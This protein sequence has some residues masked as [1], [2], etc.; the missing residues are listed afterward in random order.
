MGTLVQ[1]RFRNCADTCHRTDDYAARCGDERGDAR[2]FQSQS[3]QSGNGK[4]RAADQLPQ[5]FVPCRRRQVPDDAGV[6]RFSDVCGAS[7]RAVGAGGIPVSR[8]QLRSRRSA[9]DILGPAGR[10]VVARQ[11]PDD[12]RRESGCVAT[13]R[14][15]NSFARRRSDVRTGH[16]AG[17]AGYSRSQHLRPSR[18]GKAAHGKLVALG[19]HCQIHFSCGVCYVASTETCV[20]KRSRE[21]EFAV[22]AQPRSIGM[23]FRSLAAGLALIFLIAVPFATSAESAAPEYSAKDRWSQKRANDWYGA[24]QWLVGSN[25]IP[26]TAINELEMWQADTF[27]LATIDREL[28]WAQNIGMN[29]MRVFLHNLA[30]KQDPAGF[31]DRID[32]FLEIADKH[33]IRIMFVL[34][35]SVWDPNPQ[36][37]K[38]RAPKPHTHNSGWV[39]ATGAAILKN[40]G[41]WSTEIEPY[42]KA[43]VGRFGDDRRIVIWDL[44]NE[45][46]NEN[47][48]Y[49]STEL[50]NKAQ[51]AE[52]LLAKV[53]VWAR[54]A[55]PSQPLTSGVWKKLDFSDDSKLSAM[56]KLQLE[57]SDVITF[58]NYDPPE[59][60][61]AEIQ[62]LR[63]FHRPVICTEYMARPQGS[64]F[65]AVLPVLKGED[66]GAYNWGF[67]SGKSQTIFPWDSWEKQYGD[68]PPL[69]FHD[70]FR[71]DGTPYN[72]KETELILQL[73][74][75]A[76]AS[77]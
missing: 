44:M 16:G 42:V 76:P 61:T 56:E 11:K 52:Q 36:I 14:S 45:P 2:Y 63:H 47:G 34:L 48:Q 58:H 51:V 32:K 39:Q 62:S 3:R 19:P 5:Q 12:Q 4:L 20:T 10:C 27:D 24:Q 41:S 68:E 7:R 38:Q 13:A 72:A 67:V 77:R 18:R 75:T 73:T 50:P 49:K 74:R 8:H 69:W 64:T 70:I 71:G 29:T 46:D 30:W 55:K 21:A 54:S 40:P 15:R 28:G 57:N 22:R 33:H 31:L 60:M 59:K 66:V 65:E 26:S 25:F 53:W 6:S 23:R 37:G 9:C 17:D 43:V 1:T 35:D